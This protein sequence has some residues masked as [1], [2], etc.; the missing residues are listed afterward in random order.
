MTSDAKK[1]IIDAKKEIID[2]K[3]EIDKKEQ[4]I[5]QNLNEQTP[6]KSKPL[7]KSIE[8]GSSSKKAN[9]N[10]DFYKSINPIYIHIFTTI[11]FIL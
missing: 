10:M 5:H 1:E 2:A 9:T 8:N 4:L 6:N 11:A 3:K 7:N